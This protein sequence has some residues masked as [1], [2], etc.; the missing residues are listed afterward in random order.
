MPIRPEF[1]PLYPPNWPALSRRV[2]F[3]RAGGRCQ[4]CARP[5]LAQVRCLPDGRWFDENTRTWRDWRGRPARWPDLIEAGYIRSTRVVLAAA[6]LDN[7]PANNRLANLKGLC[8]RCHMLHDRPFH[9]AQRWLT[10]RRRW[11]LGDLFFGQYGIHPPPPTSFA[12]TLRGASS[13]QAWSNLN[14]WRPD[15]KIS[16]AWTPPQAG[17]PMMAVRPAGDL[18]KTG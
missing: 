6:H 4:R 18:F 16:A 8:Q 10:Y 1:R 9:L 15:G 3:E 13:R 14:R 11:A 12:E 7:D 5:H 17:R 2:R